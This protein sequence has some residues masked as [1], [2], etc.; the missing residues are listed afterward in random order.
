MW[1]MVG[2]AVG[3]RGG[4]M[5]GGG[6]PGAMGGTLG[7]HGGALVLDIGDEAALVICSVGHD[8]D[9]AVGERHPVLASH[10]AILILDLLLGK[11]C[12]GI[13]IL[14]AL[15]INDNFT[16]NVTH[17]NAVLIGEWSGG[18]LD[19]GVTRGVVE[20][21]V[22]W[23]VGGANGSKLGSSRGQAGTGTE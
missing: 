9:P 23:T 18:D 20:G 16:Y 3:Q 17:L 21:G 11:I 22:V 7:V 12:S 1:T 10:H 2:G 19:G 15:V 6:V 14:L 13:S 8:L 5:G 4:V